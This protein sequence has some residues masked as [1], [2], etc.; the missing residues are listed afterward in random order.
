MARLRGQDEGNNSPFAGFGG[1]GFG[2]P[3]GAGVSLDGSNDLSQ[4][5]PPQGG[6]GG[7]NFLQPSVSL[8]PTP[9]EAPNTPGG[10]ENTPSGPSQDSGGSRSADKPRDLFP[11]TP[12]TTPTPPVPRQPQTTEDRPQVP[13]FASQ[14][15]V[16]QP[17][18][19]PISLPKPSPSVLV[20]PTRTAGMFGSQGGQF[21]GGLGVPGS[22]GQGPADPSALFQMIK[23]L[24]GG[25]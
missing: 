17:V 25:Q 4:F 2:N 14:P 23:T 19:M 7:S 11:S 20:T 21:G 6:E 1:Q 16:T 24:F 8:R 3:L 10:G 5:A 22:G 13:T 18:N 12:A 9:P 15:S